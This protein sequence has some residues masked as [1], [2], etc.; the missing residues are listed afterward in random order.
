MRIDELTVPNFRGFAEASFQFHPRSNRL[1]GA[2]A[3]GKTRLLEVSRRSVD[4]S[5]EVRY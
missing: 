5:S 4:S 3:S 1:V 2:N